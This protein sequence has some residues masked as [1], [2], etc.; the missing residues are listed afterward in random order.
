MQESV[1]PDTHPPLTM[2]ALTGNPSQYATSKAQ[3]T[4][5]YA[6]N[7]G[8]VKLPVQTGSDARSRG[9]DLNRRQNAYFSASPHAPQSPNVETAGTG[10]QSQYPRSRPAEPLVAPR[11]IQ[12]YPSVLITIIDYHRDSTFDTNLF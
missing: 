9:P 12:E 3:E 1:E 7:P 11:S 2:T 5:A 6:G 8:E 10:L 4:V